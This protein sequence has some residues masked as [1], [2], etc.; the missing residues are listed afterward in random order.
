MTAPG[1]TT[2]LVPRDAAVGAEAVLDADDAHHV[3]VLRV[4]R[5]AEL[6]GIDGGGRVFR[7]TLAWVEKREMRVRIEEECGAPHEARAPL[8]II[9]A[10][11]HTARMDWLVE[12]AAEV[13][14]RGIVVLRSARSQRAAETPRLERWRRIARAAT[15]QSLGACIPEVVAAASPDNALQIVQAQVL[16][17]ADSSGTSI[18]S[19]PALDPARTTALVVGPEG[20]FADNER[21]A[22]IGEGAQPVSLGPRRLRA[23]T[24]AIVA[25]AG[26]LAATDGDFA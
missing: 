23:E 1:V 3:R 16:V 9:Q 24:A 15:I 22:W 4:P 25:A 21:S 7:V 10:A 20:G 14:V 13:G 11:L 26:L 18:R 5:G 2:V 12:K 6:R 8:W 17:L 19:V